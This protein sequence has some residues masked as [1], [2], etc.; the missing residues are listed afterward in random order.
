LCIPCLLPV[1]GLHGESITRYVAVSRL[2]GGPDRAA[3]ARCQVD[4]GP[5]VVDTVYGVGSHGDR[6][7]ASAQFWGT[8]HSQAIFQPV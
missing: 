3:L 8:G 4:L 5:A 1:D 7:W 2:A 6:T